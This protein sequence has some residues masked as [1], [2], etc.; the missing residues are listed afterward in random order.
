MHNYLQNLLPRLIQFS[1]SLEKKEMLVDQPWIYTGNYPDKQQFIFRRDGRLIQSVNGNVETGTWE[2]IAAA[3]SLLI[4][5]SSINLLFNLAFFDKG[6]L[7]LKKD[8]SKETPWALANENII[9]DLDVEKY[10]KKLVAAKQHLGWIQLDSG[11]EIEFE[12]EYS[13]GFQQGSVV[14]MNGMAVPN[15]TYKTADN[16]FYFDVSD[17][18]VNQLYIRNTYVTDR[19]DIT[20]DSIPGLDPPLRKGMK[21]WSGQ[22]PASNNRYVFKDDDTN[23][24]YID[25]RE[26]TIHKVKYS[27]NEA[28][29]AFVLVL[30]ILLLLCIIMAIINQVSDSNY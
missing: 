28:L 14:R 12:N 2:Y 7:L 30:G 27:L 6:V 19:G 20:I 29:I 3:Q 18:K 22:Y 21:V 11:E 8:G 26:G 5:S 23:A 25:V 13:T 10:L 4:Q 9:P 24:K 16:E 15:G 1:Q 17:S